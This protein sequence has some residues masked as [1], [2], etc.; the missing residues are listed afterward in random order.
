MVAMLFCQL[1][2]AKSLREITQ[3][4]ACRL[5]KLRHLG[6]NDAPKRSTLSH[7][8]GTRPWEIYERTFYDL[9][10]QCRR[11]AP[12]K[13]FQFK[14][15]LLS[16]DAT[17]FDLCA[18]LFD[19]APFRQR[20]GAVTLHLLLDHDGYLLAFRPPHR[21]QRTRDQDGPR[22]QTGPGQHDSVIAM[23]GGYFDLALFRKWCRKRVSF[24]TRMKE[25]VKREIIEE[26]PEAP[27]RPILLDHTIRLSSDNATRE[28][29]HLLQLAFVCDAGNGQ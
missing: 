25:R 24:V 7:A 14:N 29:P 28:C 18:S 21:G 11:I 27:G 9:V 23:G 8:N 6:L 4:L 3:G 13:M 10:E 26:R 22:A 2:A 17:V 12:K 19:W 1:A 15:K 20:K 5:G 16:L